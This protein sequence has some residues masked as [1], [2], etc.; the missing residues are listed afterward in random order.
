MNKDPIIINADIEAAGVRADVFLCSKLTGVSRAQLASWFKLGLIDAPSVRKPSQPLKGHEV[1]TIKPPE[2]VSGYMKP[3]AIELDILFSDEHIAIVN[4]PTGLVVHPGAG[5]P[6]GTLCNALLHRFPEMAVQ[7]MTRP[8]LVHRLD[9]ETSGLMVIAKTNEAMAT[10]SQAFKERRVKK[11]YRAFVWGEIQFKNWEI[12]SGHTRHPNNRFKFFTGLPAPLTQ[13]ANVRLAHTSIQMVKTRH[14]L[15]EVLATIHTGRTHQ[16][17]AHLADRGF[18]LIGD[19]LYGG[20][21][22]GSKAMPAEFNQ[23][24]QELPGQALHASIL[25]FHHPATNEKLR[26]QAPLPEALEKIAQLFA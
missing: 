7:N 10:L 6:D 24:M 21:H 20:R 11:V 16:I 14:G 23:A 8:G 15:T 18:P 1:F 25:E 3:E 9:K 12:K 5:V 13:N 17:R 22:L 19:D 4:K 2:V 26:F